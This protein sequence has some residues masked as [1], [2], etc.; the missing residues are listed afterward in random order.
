MYP[1]MISHHIP[2]AMR[3]ENGELLSAKFSTKSDGPFVCFDCGE[4]LVLKLGKSRVAHFSHMRGSQCNGGG[5][6]LQHRYAKHILATTLPRWSFMKNCP[7]CECPYTRT[8]PMDYQFKEHSAVEEL[9]VGPYKIDVGVVQSEKCVAAVEVYHT[10]KVD[11]EKRQ[12]LLAYGI[13]LIEVV[14]QHIIGCYEE[15]IYL[16]TFDSTV[17]CTSCS[18]EVRKKTFAKQNRPCY[19]CKTWRPIDTLERFV[20]PETHPYPIAYRCSMCVGI[21]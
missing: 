20:P 16:A 5:E 21:S 14:A 18:E 11:I 12:Y 15:E 8:G 17:P 10:H 19:D 1:T 9:A 13:P 7:R 2:V 6:S 3:E 4:Q